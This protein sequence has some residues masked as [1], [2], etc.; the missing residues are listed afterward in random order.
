[1]GLIFHLHL[2]IQFVPSSKHTPS[3][4]VKE[5]SEIIDVYAENNTQPYHA[6]TLRVEC[7]ISLMSNLVVRKA[8]TIHLT[9]KNASG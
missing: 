5:Y 1:M 8:T 6:C 7:S 4:Y 9:A 3:S 2:Y